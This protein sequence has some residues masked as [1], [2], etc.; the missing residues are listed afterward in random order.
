MKKENRE[1]KIAVIVGTVTGDLRIHKVPKLTVSLLV[2]IIVAN[3]N[4]NLFT[5]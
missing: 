4:L 3:V 5:Y 2:Y 1:G